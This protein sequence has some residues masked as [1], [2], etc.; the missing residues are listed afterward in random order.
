[1]VITPSED[2]ALTIYT[3]LSSDK[4]T[5]SINSCKFLHNAFLTLGSNA[6]RLVS[7]RLG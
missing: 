4:S 2:G 6:H 1:M 3:V 7:V 5:C